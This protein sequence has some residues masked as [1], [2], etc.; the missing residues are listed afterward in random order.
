M[1]R[2]QQLEFC[3]VCTKRKFDRSKGVVCSLTDEHAT[4]VGECESF[5]KDIEYS[6][7]YAGIHGGIVIDNKSVSGSVRLANYVIDRVVITLLMIAVFA[8]YTP[9]M[10]GGGITLEFY[11]IPATIIMCVM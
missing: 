5:D 2:Q 6:E 8:F 9:N 4:F 3:K 7:K 11:L 10:R 1:T